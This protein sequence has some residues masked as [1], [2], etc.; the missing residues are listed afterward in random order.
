MGFVTSQVARSIKGILARQG[1]AVVRPMLRFGLDPFTDIRRLAGIWKYPIR[2]VFD[3][4]AND[5]ST[6]VAALEEFPEARV[7]SFEPH[8]G[9]FAALNARINGHPRHRSV[10]AALG[11]EVGEAEMFEY[12]ESKVNSLTPNAQ[13]AMRYGKNGRSIRVKA[14]T[15]DTYCA[16]NGIDGVDVLKI[17][18]EGFD[19]V[20]LEG[21]RSMMERRAVKF[22]YVEFND[23]QP[24]EGVFGGALL[25]FDV[26]LRPYGYRFVASYNDYIGTSGEMF[27]VSN[28]LFALPGVTGA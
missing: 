23:L 3:V 15:L 14:T 17:D 21:C 22:V 9:T 5:G 28:A 8:P 13:Y 2:L 1:V 24:K 20:V 10:N 16:E 27:S 12:D 6:A 19:L 7:V 11:T 18:T 25:P 4:G 26:L